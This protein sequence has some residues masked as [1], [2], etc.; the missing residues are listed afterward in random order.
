MLNHQ[1]H[2]AGA[3]LDQAQVAVLGY[4]VLVI[5]VVDAADCAAAVK[6]AKLARH[7]VVVYEEP[8]GIGCL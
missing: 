1:R 5:V 7:G 8:L 6:L 3:L 4:V 2:A